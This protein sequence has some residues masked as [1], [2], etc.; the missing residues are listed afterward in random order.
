MTK[1]PRKSFQVR[2][3]GEG[4]RLF[5]KPSRNRSL[6]KKAQRMKR[7]RRGRLQA[8]REEEDDA[9]DFQINL[10]SS[11]DWTPKH[12]LVEQQGRK[13]RKVP[14]DEMSRPEVQTF[15]KTQLIPAADVDTRLGEM[16]HAWSD[17]SGELFGVTK[18]CAPRRFAP[19]TGWTSVPHRFSDDPILIE[20]VHDCG[21]KP[22]GPST[23]KKKST[24]SCA[25]KWASAPVCCL[26]HVL[27]TLSATDQQ[28]FLRDEDFRAQVYNQ[29]AFQ[30]KYGSCLANSLR[31]SVSFGE[32]GDYVNFLSQAEPAILR[33]RAY[34]DDLTESDRD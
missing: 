25:K 11:F 12:G 32:S 3:K 13:I 17:Q 2:G 4:G 20:M 6:P 26:R 7:N 24:N 30:S 19:G 29:R 16:T 14:A 10:P 1:A 18:R 34:F 23:P 28:R 31:T 5:P 22:R 27:S 33:D 15:I 8:E 9:R 21:A